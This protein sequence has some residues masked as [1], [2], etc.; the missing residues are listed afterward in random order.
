VSD[1]WDEEYRAYVR[2]ALPALRRLAYLL[3]QDAH[4]SDD[5]VQNTLVTLYLR[6]E[7]VRTAS[8][9]QA[10]ARTVL[11]RA[12]LSERRTSWAK[13]VVL[14][15]TVPESSLPTGLD[16]A[17]TLALRAALATLP[18]KQRAVLVLRFYE[19]LSVEET[20]EA[21]GY[22]TGTVKSH[23]ARG[24]AALRNALPEEQSTRLRS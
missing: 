23:T 18:L 2:S 13:R 1:Q 20:A 22:P 4:R 14:V 19:G 24:L 5:L 7:R 3:C 17:A 11:M 21:L 12:F 6:W 10:Y 16:A 9:V 8:S 15:D